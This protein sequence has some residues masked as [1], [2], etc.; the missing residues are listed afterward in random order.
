[1][2]ILK[3]TPQEEFEVELKHFN[4][5]RKRYKKHFSSKVHKNLKNI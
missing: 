4:K 5:N 2:K 1:M 3:L